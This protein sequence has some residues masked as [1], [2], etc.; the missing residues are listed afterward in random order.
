MHGESAVV[1]RAWPPP[2]LLCCFSRCSLAAGWAD[3]LREEA[4]GIFAASSAGRRGFSRP[5]FLQSCSRISC[6]DARLTAPAHRYFKLY[7]EWFQLSAKR[8]LF[9]PLLLASNGHFFCTV[10]STG[11]GLCRFKFALVFLVFFFF[12]T[13]PDTVDGALKCVTA[14]SC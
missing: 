12:F 6:T 13:L 2:D 4:A 7:V 10:P 9:Q 14:G 8:I 3:A 1:D 5:C 11:R